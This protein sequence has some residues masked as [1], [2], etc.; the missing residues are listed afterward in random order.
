M[1]ANAASEGTSACLCVKSVWLFLICL[2]AHSG[3]HVDR[4]YMYLAYC[5]F[6]NITVYTPTFYIISSVVPEMY[7]I[8]VRMFEIVF[9]IKVGIIWH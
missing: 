6:F 9:V 5:Y 8:H 1:A 7:N 3:G 2:L 4:L